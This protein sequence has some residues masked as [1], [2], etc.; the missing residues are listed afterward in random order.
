MGRIEQID[1]GLEFIGEQVREARQEASAIGELRIG[2]KLTKLVSMVE[3]R[4][5]DLREDN[6]LEG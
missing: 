3:K 2:E 4:R 5:R 6:L 1:E